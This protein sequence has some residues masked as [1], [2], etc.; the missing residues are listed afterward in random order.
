MCVPVHGVETNIGAEVRIR[1][2]RAWARTEPSVDRAELR[3]AH[4]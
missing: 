1:A 4:P 3:L 2:G